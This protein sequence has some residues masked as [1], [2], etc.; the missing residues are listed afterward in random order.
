ISQVYWQY[1]LLHNRTHNAQ[2]VSRDLADLIEGEA[3]FTGPYAPTLTI[4]NHHRVVIYSFGLATDDADLFQRFPISHVAV[5]I[6]DADVASQKFTELADN[7][8]INRWVLR[9]NM[10]KVLQLARDHESRAPGIRE[11]IDAKLAKRDHAKALKIAREVLEAHPANRSGRNYM[12]QTLLASSLY[13]EAL[14][15]ARSM[16]ER[17]DTD[18]N[19]HLAL[20]RLC[21]S[22][23]ADGSRADLEAEGEKS[24]A[25]AIELNPSA[26]NVIEQSAHTAF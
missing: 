8:E 23:N 5:N 13:G 26:R 14:H 20:A 16:V 2:I 19:A 6:S 24:L 25:R 9:N 3:V 11:L 15:I 17:D 1:R 22:L 12:L 18:F 10:V 7:R 21:F 4:D